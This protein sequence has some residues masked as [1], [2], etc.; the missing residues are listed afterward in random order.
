MAKTP[1]HGQGARAVQLFWLH[2]PV[3]AI[4]YLV[5]RTGAQLLPL[6]R[7]VWDV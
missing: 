6:A 4:N 5:M 2:C 3:G 1:R 7:F